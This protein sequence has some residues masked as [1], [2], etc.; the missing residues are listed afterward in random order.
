MSVKIITDSASDITR[1][2]AAELGI[3]VIPMTT[4]FK[5]VEYLDGVTLTNR[6]FFEKLIETD[7][8]PHT[9]QITPFQ[10]GETFRRVVSA[11]DEAVYIALSSKLSGSCGGAVT[12]AAEFEGRVTVV[13]SENVC[14]GQQLLVLYAV[15]LRDRGMSAAAIAEEL[16]AR[17]G[18][19]R[20][21]ALLDTLEYLKKGGRISPTVAFAGELLSIKPVVAVE[22]G[23]VVLVGKARGSKNGN[24]LLMRFVEQSGGIDFDM[25]YMLAYS[26]LDD[27]L[28]QKYIRDSEALYKGRAEELPVCA[29]GST[30]G[31]HVGPGAIAVAFFRGEKRMK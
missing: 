24:N 3:E 19:V 7:E 2:R 25:P 4:V 11:G 31:T 14:I 6:E 1:A 5:D 10:Y 13:D 28:L 9:S 26:G 30:I 12:A 29:I 15:R 18:D 21:L 23:E 16:E 8:L 20:V 17:R 27:T 22:N